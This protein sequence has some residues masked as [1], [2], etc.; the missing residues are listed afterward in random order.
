MD[1]STD[2]VTKTY[3]LISEEE[4]M[5]KKGY[6]DYKDPQTGE[7]KRPENPTFAAPT[8]DNPCKWKFRFPEQFIHSTMPRSIEVHNITI[9]TNP[10]EKGNAPGINILNNSVITGDI[11][12]HSNFIKRDPY[13]KHTV[14]IC[15]QMRTKFK[16]Y[17]Y[18]SSDQTFDV[19]FTSFSDPTWVAQADRTKFIIEMMLIY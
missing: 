2:K 19:W 11:V 8:S 1:T 15:N 12:M 10:V 14:M 7:M 16:K 3:F 4:D 17:A 18:L 9:A 5:Y 6:F 13:L